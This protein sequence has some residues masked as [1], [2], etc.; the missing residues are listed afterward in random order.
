MFLP[1]TSEESE[2]EKAEEQEKKRC[3]E[4][5]EQW[6]MKAIPE[7]L[8][9]N[10]QINASDI[11]CGDPQCAPVDTCIVILF[12]S[13]GKGMLGIPADPKNV[14]E[15]DLLDYFPPERILTKWHKGEDAEWPEFDDEE[16]EQPP[17]RFAVGQEVQ[18]RIGPDPVTG[19]T[20]G[21]IVQLWYQE[22]G[23]PPDSWAPYKIRL[24]DG[25]SIFAPGDVDQII[26]ARPRGSS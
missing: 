3:L 1:K 23:W 9:D 16:F 25:R 12:P 7:P 8:R 18:C 5:I 13:G 6:S 14:T 2:K 11:I 10:V 22:Q 17:L 20:D 19:W 24:T 26:R 15:T 21:V 4:K